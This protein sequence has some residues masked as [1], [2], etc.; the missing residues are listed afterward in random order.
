MADLL[1][2]AD[3][4][5]CYC[6]P[7]IVAQT[8]R[9]HGELLRVSASSIRQTKVILDSLLIRRLRMEIALVVQMN[10]LS[11]H[12]PRSQRRYSHMDNFRTFAGPP[13]VSQE[14]I[15]VVYQ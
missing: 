8:G 6:D 10:A 9:T 15:A 7:F 4:S 3:E 12:M 2:P 1:G 11:M 13:S 14:A 5:P